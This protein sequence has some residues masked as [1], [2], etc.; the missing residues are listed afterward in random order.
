M[1]PMTEEEYAYWAEMVNEQ[2]AGMKKPLPFDE[3]DWSME[4]DCNEE[5]LY[6]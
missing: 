6:G 3:V 2:L 1:I 4:P 5:E